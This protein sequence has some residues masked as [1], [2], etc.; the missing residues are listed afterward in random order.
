MQNIVG[1]GAVK[2]DV[3][4]GSMLS[5]CIS[6]SVGQYNVRNLARKNESIKYMS[7]KYVALEQLLRFYNVILKKSKNVPASKF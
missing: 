5:G 3:Q 4:D 6:K 7:L 2:N 1:S